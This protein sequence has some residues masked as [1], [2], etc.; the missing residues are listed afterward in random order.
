MP[1]PRPLSREAFAAI[2]AHSGLTLDHDT[3]EEFLALYNEYLA[4]ILARLRCREPLESEVRPAPP[5]AR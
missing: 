5:S 2:A 1:E 3:L 4:P